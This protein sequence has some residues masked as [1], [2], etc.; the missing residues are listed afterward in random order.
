ME[1]VFDIVNDDGFYMEIDIKPKEKVYLDMSVREEEC[2]SCGEVEEINNTSGILGVLIIKDSGGSIIFE[3]EYIMGHTIKNGS[4]MKYVRESQK[5]FSRAGGRTLR[6]P[7]E[8]RDDDIINYKDY[9]DS[10]GIDISEYDEI[11]AIFEFTCKDISYVG[12]RED[13]DIKRK[14]SDKIDISRKIREMVSKDL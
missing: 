8:D 1:V 4:Q 7:L 10:S 13:I 2:P 11:E 9:I 12:D 3:D 6:F 5:Y 14:Y